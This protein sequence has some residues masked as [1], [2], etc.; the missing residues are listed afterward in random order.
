VG[1]IYVDSRVG[2]KDLLAPL[3]ALGLEAELTTL[4]FGDVCFEG[5]GLKG[6]LIEIGIEL[7]TLGDAINSLRSGRLSG[8]QLPGLRNT[9]T[10]A[11]LILE[12][13]WRQNE[14]GQMTTY[15]GR[16]GWTVLPG[17]MSASEFEK[18]ILTLELC[19]GLIARYTNSR[20]DTVRFIAALYRWFSDKAMDQ[21]R[22][23][24]KT[25][26]TPT[27]TPVSAYRAFYMKI[28]GVGYR[29]SQAVE[30]H[31]KGGP[32]QAS[33]ASIDE[34]ANIMQVSDEGKSRKLGNTVATRIVSFLRG[35]L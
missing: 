11:W 20:V 9:Y 1:V 14:F 21:H 29:L 17:K 26:D 34:W 5:K 4:E 23:H 8:H 12:G 7:K 24:L 33:C 35:G 30:N 25:H 15:Q 22:S 16:R 28:P 32:R 31:F 19:G 18:Q 13:Q 2:S 6:S 3:Q 10:Y 27:L